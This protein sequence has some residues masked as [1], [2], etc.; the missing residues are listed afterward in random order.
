MATFTCASHVC[1]LRDHCSGVHRTNW[2]VGGLGA[3]VLRCPVAAVRT[4]G[5]P[6]AGPLVYVMTPPPLMSPNA[7]WP[8]MQTTINTLYPKL[9]PMMRMATPGV[10]GAF[11][12][13]LTTTNCKCNHA[14]L[15]VRRHPWAG[16]DVHYLWRTGRHPPSTQLPPSRVPAFVCCLTLKNSRFNRTIGP[17]VQGRSMSSATWAASRTGGTSSHQVASSIHHGQ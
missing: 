16:P 11:S 9:I 5:L 2:C 13:F 10:R 7:G 12:L 15:A 8:T 14:G 1:C 6:Q 17:R 4:W 3:S